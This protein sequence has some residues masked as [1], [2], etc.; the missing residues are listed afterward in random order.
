MNRPLII[1][2]GIVILLLVLG[3]WVYLMLFGTP[4]DSGEVFS[5]LGFEIASQPVTITPPEAGTALPETTVDTY[6]E[7]LRQLTT[8]PVAGFTFIT[9]ASSTLIHYVERGTGHIYEINLETG[10]ETPLSRTTIPQTTEAVFSPSG[11]TVALTT[12]TQYS[13]SVFVGEVGEEVNLEGI[14]LQPGA[15]NISFASD[16]DIL[17]TITENGNTTGYRHNIYTL[18]QT[19]QFSF[20]YA[21]VDVAWGEGLDKTYLSTKPSHDLEGYIYSTKNDVLTPE[22][23][24]AYGLSALFSNDYIVTTYTQDGQYT[25]TAVSTTEEYSSL[26]T[27]A[28]KEKCVFDSFAPS[29]LWCAAPLST[30]S[31]TFVE[32]WYKGKITAADNLWLIDIADS[33]ATFYADFTELSGRTVDVKQLEIEQ[34]GTALSFINKLDHTLWLY[35]LT[36]E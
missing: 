21:N 20:N 13:T 30:N 15:T 26:P 6:G 11:S 18:S 36:V 8:R 33:S 34:N 27:L 2:A 16:E 24:S 29:Y 31:P 35:D 32:D 1:T 4:D 19:E 23:F 3:L 17:Y 14:R 12:H 7:K 28:L 25:S 10:K 5:N 22:I 9:Q